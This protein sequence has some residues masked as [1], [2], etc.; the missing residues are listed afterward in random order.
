[1]V[2]EIVEMR[3]KLKSTIFC[4]QI[5]PQGWPQRLNNGTVAEAIMDR[6]VHNSIQLMVDG[7]LSM[8]ERHGLDSSI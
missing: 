7:E 3:Y 5:H 4:S 2:L 1:M 6:I 8:R